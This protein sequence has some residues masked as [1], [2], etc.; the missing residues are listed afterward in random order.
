M[1]DGLLDVFVFKGLGFSYAVSHMLKMLSR[2]HLNDPRVIHRKARRIV[3]ETEAATPVQI[4]GD[5]FG[6]TPVVVEVVPR[7]LRIVVPPKAP[8][9]LFSACA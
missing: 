2:R 6:H 9:S 1:D 5:P 4:D 7:A 3:V 8:P